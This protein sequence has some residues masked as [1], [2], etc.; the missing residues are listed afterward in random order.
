[1]VAGAF[2]T[3]PAFAQGWYAGLSIGQGKADLGSGGAGFSGSLD[4]KD[5]TFGARLGYDFTRYFGMELGYYNLGK[6]NFNGTFSGL[7]V[8]GNADLKSYSVSVVGTLPF[9]EH[10]SAY[11]KAGYARSRA[12]GNANI[13]GFGGNASD[14]T[15]EAVYGAGLKWMVDRQ[16]GL[17]TEWMRNDDNKVDNYMV[18]AL[19]RF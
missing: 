9:S 19:I 16:W 4:D 3:A 14:W 8:S 6:Y 10:F 12:T 18:G 7:P 17:F 5:T 1:M 2:A 13:A 15:N 11:G